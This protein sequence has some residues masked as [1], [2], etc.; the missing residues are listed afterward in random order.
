MKF[1]HFV[2]VVL[3]SKFRFVRKKQSNPPNVMNKQPVNVMT[4]PMRTLYKKLIHDASTMNIIEAPIIA[5]ATDVL[6]ESPLISSK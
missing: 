3:C 1:S 4:V 6:L 2:I 5:K